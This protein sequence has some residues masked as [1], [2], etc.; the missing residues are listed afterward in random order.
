MIR[1]FGKWVGLAWK[2]PISPRDVLLLLVVVSFSSYALTDA[3]NSETQCRFDQLSRKIDVLSIENAV[4][5]LDLG[6]DIYN[7]AQVSKIGR[8]HV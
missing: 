4:L 3:S 6:E 8:A 2:S 7:S 5:R 1:R